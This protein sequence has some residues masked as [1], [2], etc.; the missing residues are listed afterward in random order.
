MVGAESLF[1]TEFQ[2]SLMLFVAFMGYFITTKIGQNIV[3]TEILLGILIG[4]T[5]LGLVTYTDII[6]VLAQFGAIFLLFAIGMELKFKEIYNRKS[7]LIALFGVVVPWIGGFAVASAFNYPFIKAVFVG[8]ALT[9][10]SIAITA[11]VL[12]EMRVLDS[13]TAKAIIGA[14]VVDDILGLLALSLT[15]GVAANSIS[16]GSITT[17]IIT[18]VAFLLVGAFTG[19]HLSKMLFRMEGIAKKKGT[20]EMVFLLAIAI[21]FLY[22]A[23]AEFIGLSAVVGAFIAGVSLE[24][25]K[26]PGFREGARYL[27]VIF[28]A[29]FFVSI[30]ILF[31]IDIKAVTELIPF[32]VALTV[33]AFMTKLVGCGVGARICGMGRRESTVIGMGMAPRGEVAIIVAL[34]GLNAGVIGQGLYSA[35]IA[36]SLLTTVLTPPLLK[37]AFQWYRQEAT[38]AYRRRWWVEEIRAIRKRIRK[39]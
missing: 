38:A 10:T 37:K 11:N 19:G 33:V 17:T 23:I 3:I 36:M 25:V 31:N 29:I 13:G 35:I 34:I 14:A 7:F 2:I 18:A 30:G 39:R 8:T 21:A 28:A 22:S 9:A 32:V 20:S 5:I 26:S 15:T 6:N 4:P 12:R 27:E 1:A 16:F 24:N